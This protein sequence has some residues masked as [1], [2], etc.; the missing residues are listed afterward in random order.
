[1]TGHR[2]RA[3]ACIAALLV[4]ACGAPP[5]PDFE[6]L[7]F[8]SF[9]TDVRIA[10]RADDP[11]ADAAAMEITDFFGRADRDWYAWGGGELSRVN[12]ALAGGET[13]QL[14]RPLAHLLARAISLHR[15]SG[16]LFDPG[17]GALVELWG[18]D[19][20]EHLAAVAG[21][22][23][24]TSITRRMADSGGA[25]ELVLEGER[26]AAD[27][28]V[29]IDL[30]GIAK[31]A[32]LERCRTILRAHGIE[33]ALLDIGGSSLLALGQ[34]GG[35]HWRVAIRD[36][37]AAEAM[38]VIDLQDGETVSTSGDYQRFY[39]TAEGRRHHVIDPRTGRPASSAIAVTVVHTDGILADAASTA[40]MVGGIREFNRLTASMGIDIALLVGA[41]GET[42]TTP[43]MERRLRQSAGRTPEAGAAASGPGPPGM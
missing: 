2:R 4:S 26:I 43:A 5:E 13:V 23:D 31:G 15:L 32:A 30:G 38:G 9:G 39:D 1:M 14:S 18:F 42:L 3:A 29:F 33:D 7:R 21:P 12:A 17:V 27:R 28:P 24:A 19:S 35:R 16:G 41:N 25:A 20:T 6:T 37:R 36:P 34:R 8:Q 22:P 11:R 40:L 10:L